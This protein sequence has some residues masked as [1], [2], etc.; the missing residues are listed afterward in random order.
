[1]NSFLFTG[2]SG[3]LGTNLKPW[4]QEKYLVKTMGLGTNDDYNINIA[5]TIPEITEKFDVILHAAGKA[6]AVPKTEAEEKSFFDINY[7][8]TINLCKALEQSG[9]PSAFIFISTVAVYGLEAGEN[10]TE[11][12]PLNGDTPYALSKIKAEQFLTQWCR[13]NNV[14]LSIIRPSLIAGPNPPGNLGAMIKGIKT[15]RYLSIADGKARKSVLMVQDIARLLPALIEKGGVYNVCDDTQPTFRELEILIARQSGKKP[16]QSIPYWLAK[17][18]ALAG[19]LLGMKAP[20]N[21]LKLSKITESLT[22]SNEKA[23]RE[24]N[25]QPLNVLNNFK[26]E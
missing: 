24:L 2:S 23:K 18:M 20:I 12:Y 3:F 17:S 15:G 9:F 11:E 22:F 10:I 7:Q 1:M 25:W 26:I 16:P 13:K 4:L 8:G 14:V 5:E 6:H 21:L 19:D